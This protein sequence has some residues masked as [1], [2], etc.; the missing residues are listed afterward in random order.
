[1]IGDGMGHGSQRRLELAQRLISIGQLN[2]AV[3]QLRQVL[4]DDP[5]HPDAHALMALVLHDQLRLHAA[6]HEAHLAVTLEPEGYLPLLA[7]GVILLARRRLQEAQE[8]FE[9][10]QS[11]DPTAPQ[12]LRMLARVR[13]LQGRR[14]EAK[15]LLDQALELDPEDVETLTDLGQWHL[16]TGDRLGAEKWARRAL[17]IEPEDQE[18]LVLMG[19]ILLR[20]GRTEEAREHAVWALQKDPGDR[21][22]LI[23]LS[24][25]KARKNPLLGLWWRYSVWMG[26]LGAGRAIFVLLVAY[27]LYRFGVITAGHM[28]Q[29][30]L[31]GLLRMVWLAIVAYTWFGPA[32]FSRS[33]QRE[34]AEV[35]LREDF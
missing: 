12:P 10:L 20:E 25:V 9:H 1:M 24:S 30:N 17:E 35:T 29:E 3:E 13:A 31:G 34:L 32:L 27:V 8:R 14:K 11:L 7:S 16:D 21:G 4:S 6:E 15:P 22:A 28:E 5:D 23:L 33:V 19:H 18:A 26:S 2:G